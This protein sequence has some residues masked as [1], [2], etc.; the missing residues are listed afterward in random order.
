ML[1]KQPAPLLE[2]NVDIWCALTPEWTPE[3]V[4]ARRDAGQEV[5]WY[6]CCGPTSPYITEFIDH[7]GS[8][9][10]LWPWQSWQYGVQGLLVWATTYWTSDCAY[11]GGKPQDPWK[12]PMSYVSGYEF[13]AGYM[14]YWGNGD[15]RFLYP[16]Q[17]VSSK[18]E[19]CLKGPVNSVRWENLRDGMED[20]EYFWLLD[21]AI[22]QAEKQKTHGNLLD[23][24]RQL[25]QVPAAIST[26]TTH[27]TTDA[28]LLM[29]HR[30]R[31]AKMIEKL[32]AP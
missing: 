8:E 14:G 15:G 9:L 19:P 12:D 11:P 1:T 30:D 21:Q 6:I 7:P 25:L 17:E 2:G 28:R 20:Y 27:F 10:R 4:K 29:E 22:K 32:Q 24:A 13:Q 26:D 31:V 3:K 23:Q 5:W 16:P 18:N